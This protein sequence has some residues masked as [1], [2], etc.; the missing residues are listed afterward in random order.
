MCNLCGGGI[1]MGVRGLLRGACVRGGRTREV[2]TLPTDF[3][4]NAIAKQAKRA[5]YCLNEIPLLD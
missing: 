3:R 2:S 5:H 1:G 4:S